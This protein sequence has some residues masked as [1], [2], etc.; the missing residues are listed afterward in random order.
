MAVLLPDY[1]AWIERLI[2][3]TD[4]IDVLGLAQVPFT[5]E[6]DLGG[7]SRYPTAY[8]IPGADVPQPNQLMRQHQQ[9]IAS[10]G[11]VLLAVRNSADR[12]GQAALSDLRARRAQIID[13]LAGWTPTGAD[14]ALNWTSG[15]ILTFS[16]AALWW[17]D[18]FSA[19]HILHSGG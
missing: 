1:G 13:A 11:S 15:S 6:G 7:P 19:T 16:P 2:A 14:F 17:L 4:G 8:V 9:Q 12:R 10:S 18:E 3:Q 5:P